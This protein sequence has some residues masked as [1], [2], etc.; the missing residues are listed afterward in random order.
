MSVQLE[1]QGAF[2]VKELDPFVLQSLESI[3]RMS[4]I[5]AEDLFAKWEEYSTGTKL[6]QIPRPEDIDGFRAHITSKLQQKLLTKDT[7]RTKRPLMNLNPMMTPSKSAP[8]KLLDAMS[9]PPFG[10]SAFSPG[11]K[12]LEFQNRLE[13]GKLQ[14]KFNDHITKLGPRKN[15]SCAVSLVPGQ[16]TKGYRYLYEKLTERGDLI[17]DRIQFFAELIREFQGD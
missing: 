13:K 7:L 17:D 4:N 11:E 8:R 16:Q 9:S 1:I 15:S 3:M 10:G 5:S 12:T 2:E 14:V 6:S